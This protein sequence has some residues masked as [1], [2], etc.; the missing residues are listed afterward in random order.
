MMDAKKD[1]EKIKALNQAIMGQGGQALRF[2]FESE[3]R[4]TIEK[5]TTATIEE[6]PTLKERIA[7]IKDLSYKL[8]EEIPHKAKEI[9]DE[10]NA[11]GR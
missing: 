3:L 4:D 9:E 7:T 8:F 11:N 2:L 6:F 5:I 1:C 10:E